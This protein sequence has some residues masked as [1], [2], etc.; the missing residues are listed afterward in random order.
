M[1]ASPY[2]SFQPEVKCRRSPL[3]V[4]KKKS[5]QATERLQNQLHN[6]KQIVNGEIMGASIAYYLEQHYFCMA[7]AEAHVQICSGVFMIGL[8]IVLS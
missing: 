5:W 3:P 6:S 7:I 4:K 2:A 8:S 1:F